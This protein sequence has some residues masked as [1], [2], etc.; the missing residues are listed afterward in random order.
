MPK[1]PDFHGPH[2][3][4]PTA[5]HVKLTWY[6]PNPR[7]SRI[8]V[9]LHTCECRETIYELCAA[10][11]LSFVC[12]TDRAKQTVRETSWTLTATAIRIF[13]QILCGEAR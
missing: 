5:E 3:E 7:A 9:I 8:R 10:A 13:A 2:V 4:P 1:I 11:G 6:E 12:R